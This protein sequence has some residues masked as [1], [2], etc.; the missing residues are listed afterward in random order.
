MRSS[1]A[2]ISAVSLEGSKIAPQPA[3]TLDRVSKPLAERVCLGKCFCG[4]LRHFSSIIPEPAD[5]DRAS[6]DTLGSVSFGF[7]SPVEDQWF[8]DLL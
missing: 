7:R 1:R 5:T 4:A 8:Q 3:Q 6:I 2:A